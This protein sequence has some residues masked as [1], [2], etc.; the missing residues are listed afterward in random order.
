MQIGRNGQY[1][2]SLEHVG[3]GAAGIVP[4]EVDEIARLARYG[5]AFG[6]ERDWF[7]ADGDRG[8]Q[9]ARLPS[10]AIAHEAM[11]GAMG[12]LCKRLLIVAR[13]GWLEA[14]DL[15]HGAGVL[16]EQQAGPNDPGVVED[17]QC[18]VRQAVGQVAEERLAD[19]PTAID[20]QFGG[21]ALGQGVLRN[22]IVGECVRVIADVYLLG[23]M[24]NGG[25]M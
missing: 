10:L 20:E 23:G 21:V 15:D 11:P 17:K 18:T 2:D 25:Q 3:E 16:A 22:P 5:D 12:R 6:R 14:E 13:H 8:V 9:L 24:H 4:A 19:L 1:A 7:T